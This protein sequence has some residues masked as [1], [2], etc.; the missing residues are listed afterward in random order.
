M[1]VYDNWRERESVCAGVKFQALWSTYYVPS[2]VPDA[3]SIVTG[4]GLGPVR[5]DRVVHGHTVASEG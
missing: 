5:P 4:I 2:S 3:G 1:Y